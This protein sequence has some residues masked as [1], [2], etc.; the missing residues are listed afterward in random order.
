MVIPVK[1][2]LQRCWWNSSM[3]C[4]SEFDF[5]LDMGHIWTYFASANICKHDRSPRVDRLPRGVSAVNQG[6]L[7]RSLRGAWHICTSSVARLEE[8]RAWPRP[9]GI[10][11]MALWKWFTCSTQKFQKQMFIYGL[12]WFVI[13][14]I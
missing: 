10:W 5:D 2:H 7:L 8:C 11:R 14:H 6:H 13:S 9:C 12:I 4:S 1:L 3:A